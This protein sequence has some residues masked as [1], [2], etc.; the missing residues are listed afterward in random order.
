MGLVEPVLTTAKRVFFVSVI[1]PRLLYIAQGTHSAATNHNS[2]MNIL[3]ELCYG[4]CIKKTI[5]LLFRYI[6]V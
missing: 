5:F 3:T 4:D 1:A 2:A 6:C